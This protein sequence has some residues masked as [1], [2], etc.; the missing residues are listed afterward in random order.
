M[1]QMCTM[2]GVSVGAT[3]AGVK[4]HEAEQAFLQPYRASSQQFLEL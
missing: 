2:H 3:E 1:M 4:A